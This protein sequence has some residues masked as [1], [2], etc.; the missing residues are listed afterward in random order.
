MALAGPAV[1]R[2]GH[3]HPSFRPKLS[4]DSKPTSTRPCR[5]RSLLKIESEACTDHVGSP[6]ES[7]PTAA[8]AVGGSG[9]RLAV[10]KASKSA[11]RPVVELERTLGQLF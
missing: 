8:L 4:I 2:I 6:T 1:S 7:S 3:V 10:L 11:S 9:K 5:C